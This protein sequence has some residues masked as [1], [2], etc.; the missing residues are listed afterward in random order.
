MRRALLVFLAAWAIFS[1]TS[2]AEPPCPIRYKMPDGALCRDYAAEWYDIPRH[3][4][5]CSSGLEYLDPP[6]FERVER[7]QP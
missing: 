1:F 4:Y 6:S 2:C 7:C 5:G 3:F